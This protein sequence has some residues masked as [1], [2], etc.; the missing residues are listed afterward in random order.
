MLKMNRPLIALL[1][2][3]I[4]VLALANCSDSDSGSA[5]TA[6]SAGEAG[7]AGGAGAGSAG[8]SGAANKGGATGDAGA[9]A[10][11]AGAGNESGAAD[12]GGMGGEPPLLGQAGTGAGPG[13]GGSAGDTSGPSGPSGPHAGPILKYTFNEGAGLVATDGSGL[14]FNAAL[15]LAAWTAQ[16]RTGAA[17][18]LGG[19]IPPTAYV[20]V[21]PGVFKDVKETTIAA[22][23]KLN[24]DG[25]WARIFDFGGTGLG[26]DTRF[27]YLTTNTPNGVH[28]SVFGGSPQREA[29]VESHTLLPL[30]VWK[31]VAV[32]AAVG[33]KHAIYIDGFPA[34]EADTF[35]VPPSELEPLSASTWLGKS[36]FAPDPGLNGAMDDFTVYDRVLTPTEIA[37]LAYPKADYSRLAFDE[38][39]GST[40]ADSSDR[41]VTATLNG[42]VTWATGRLGAAVSLSGTAQYVTLDNPIAG[43]TNELTVAMW[44]K[45]V[46][47]TAWARLLDFGGTNDN[48]M[49]LTP[50]GT[51]GNLQLNI[52]TTAKETMV[53]STSTVPTDSAWHHVAIVVSPVAATIFLDGAVT[54]SAL[55]PVTPSVLGTTNEHWL[56]K[57]RFPVDPYFSGAFDEVRISCRAFTPDEIKS[58]A[59]H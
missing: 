49:F 39:T 17:L 43:C 27:M 22:W 13:E 38:G 5:P 18:Q 7:G 16:G 47:A 15:S 59:F 46:T 14:G 58:L 34:A 6:G 35:D 9:P 45:E 48:F 53:L 20:T 29:V 41:A 28:F 3:S 31:H 44:V 57:S 40:S 33:G 56:G 1:S 42:G 55:L 11:A 52:H 25:A 50:N 10:S 32:T 23:V 21:P 2:G 37:A 24:V 8:K 26:T 51:G 19:G 12:E 4:S 54:G 36:R 30:G